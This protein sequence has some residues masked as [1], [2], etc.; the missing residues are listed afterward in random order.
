MKKK[1]LFLIIAVTLSQSTIA[2]N[3]EP[4]W[5]SFL[6]VFPRLFMGM[7]T[8]AKGMEDVNH[9][10]AHGKLRDDFQKSMKKL[11]KELQNSLI[12]LKDGAVKLPSYLTSNEAKTAYKIALYY[13]TK[14]FLNLSP[15]KKDDAISGLK[16]LL[17]NEK[18]RKLIDEADN[19]A[20][21]A[22]YPSDIMLSV[23][24]IGQAKTDK[25]WVNIYTEVTDIINKTG[26]VVVG[27]KDNTVPNIIH[28]P[29]TD[30]LSMMNKTTISNNLDSLNTC[31][32]KIAGNT[33]HTG[34]ADYFMGNQLKGNTNNITDDTTYENHE[35]RPL[36][37]VRQGHTLEKGSVIIKAPVD[38]KL[39][40][41][42][43]PAD[44]DSHLTGPLNSQGE[45]FHTYF[46]NKGDLNGT[47]HS[48]LY[49]DITDHTA[50]GTNTH[51]RIRLN[52]IKPGKY[53]FYV[54]DFT[55]NDDA[56]S[57][58]L[59]NSGATVDV[60]STKITNTASE[61]D[62]MKHL[63]EFKVPISHVSDPQNVPFNE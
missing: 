12:A 23:L 8:A 30:A 28:S 17:F 40:W 59:S 38:F 25:D 62:A 36:E 4:A 11:P 35:Y 60:Y 50:N 57:S 24:N 19:T 13:N 39:N 45:R 58:A 31:N 52:K 42:A 26:K 15:A 53:N 3:D 44:L 14:P 47:T 41:G 20:D 21:F 10:M 48:E 55:N 51:E 46:E 32:A 18:E 63:A 1:L 34:S 27:K 56:N 5:K 61:N 49:V 6:M 2:K 33:S 54:H 22:H 9:S 43:D 29:V 37:T 7:G 16:H